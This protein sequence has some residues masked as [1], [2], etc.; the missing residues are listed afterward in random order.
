MWGSPG[1]P[2]SLPGSPNLPPCCRRTC[3]AVE[4]L[5]GWQGSR[6]L[7]GSPP[8]RSGGHPTAHLGAGCGTGGRA[9]PGARPPGPA[10]AH[11][12]P[13][14][15]PP[16]G[17]APGLPAD[18]PV[19]HAP[20]GQDGRHRGG[21]CSADA[22][23]H[24]PVGA[25]SRPDHT[26]AKVAMQQPRLRPSGQDGPPWGRYHRPPPSPRAHLDRRMSNY[27]SP[28]PLTTLIAFWQGLQLRTAGGPRAGEA[29]PA[30]GG[31][32]A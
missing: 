15:R 21:F 8:C 13:T 2:Y 14:A 27:A 28:G 25:A 9:Q 22:D 5:L 7:P 12:G 19:S 30:P 6:Q 10:P 24:W 29:C 31:I 26:E 4:S 16:E 1:L 18:P 20:G 23:N 3:Q 17:P 32:R 11:T